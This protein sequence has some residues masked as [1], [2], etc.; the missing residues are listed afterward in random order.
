MADPGAIL[1]SA[2]LARGAPQP[3]IRLC[4]GI[5]LG[6]C[7]TSATFAQVQPLFPFRRAPTVDL[8]PQ[9]QLNEAANATLSH[10]ERVE[11]FLAAKQWDEAVETL[12][13]VLESHRSEVIRAE[14]GPNDSFVRYLPVHRYCQ[15]LLV[16]LHQRAPEALRLYR[17]RVDPLARRWLEQGRRDRDEELL[18]RIVDQMFA[19]SYG[20]DALMLLGEY[21]LERGAWETARDDWE[22]ISPRLRTPI[23][24]G[25]VFRQPAGA[26]LWLALRGWRFDNR[27][28]RLREVMSAPPLAVARLAHPDTDLDLAEVRA[29]LTL[30]SI[31]QGQRERAGVELALLRTLA[32]QAEGRLAARKGRFVDILQRLLDDSRQWKWRAT[33]TDWPQFAGRFDRNPPEMAD[34][35]LAGRPLWVAPL[36]PLTDDGERIAR[37]RPR[38]AETASGLLSVHPVVIGD[39]IYVPQANQ[40]SA[41]HVQSGA[42]AFATEPI[43]DPRKRHAKAVIYQHDPRQPPPHASR[44]NVGVPRFTLS[45]CGTKLFAR[46][47]SPATASPR[48]LTAPPR[49]ELQGMIVGLD[50]QA[51]GKL[52]PGFPLRP[53]DMFWS[54]E[55]PPV[56]DGDQLYV[57]MRRQ[58]QVRSQAFVAC[59]DLRTGERRWR[60]KIVAADTP[61]QGNLTENTHN[62]LTLSEATLYLNSNMGAIAAL[63]TREGAVKW[64]VGY[65]RAAFRP[66]HPD[67]TDRTFFRDLNPCLVHQGIVIAA[68]ADCERIFGLDQASGQRLWATP[69]D[70]A[71]D[72][73]HVLG[74]RDDRLFLSGDSLYWFDLH[75]GKLLCQ[76]PPPKKIADGFALPRERGHGRG[77]LAG[78]KIYFPTRERIYVFHQKPGRMGEY[79]TPRLARAPIELKP[80]GAEGGNLI[81]ARGLLFIAAAQRLFAFDPYGRA[82]AES[83]PA[84]D[85]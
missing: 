41:Y 61:G 31:L 24:S 75:T 1:R 7:L 29:R 33:A 26:P 63:D 17:S 49:P 2:R 46:V 80:R 85:R 39:R 82:A 36:T 20:D 19:S 12:R 34:V 50:L 79:S 27:A 60:T 32:P 37:G 15:L 64:I 74:A 53:D 67:A 14:G 83:P 8:S 71:A 52:L 4:L 28:N 45:S 38:T 69:A 73:V 57:A 43:A 48:Q 22:R 44:M 35:D 23:T 65:R 10:L 70:L 81:V 21:A 62:L 56:C 13:R 18:R 40:I 84:P 54:F 47:G 6:L 3:W 58:D 16:G 11:E 76:F 55:G 51:Q 25:E 42:P 30:V 5:V 68:P 9:I 59:Y 66:R 78:G 72:A 77:V